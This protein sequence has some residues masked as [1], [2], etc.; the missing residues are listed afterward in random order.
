MC[1]FQRGSPRE[2]CPTQF[3]PVMGCFVDYRLFT[4]MHTLFSGTCAFISTFSAIRLLHRNSSTAYNNKQSSG[5]QSP[6]VY[7]A[8]PSSRAQGQDLRLNCRHRAPERAIK[9]CPKGLFAAK[10]N[11][12]ALIRIYVPHSAILFK[13]TMPRQTRE[14]AHRVLFSHTHTHH[15]L[16]CIVYGSAPPVFPHAYLLNALH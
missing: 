5:A 12:H 13:S 7:K 10:K 2:Q 6:P 9:P 4:R 1:F 16:G 14:R 11:I 3:F 8:S 15:L